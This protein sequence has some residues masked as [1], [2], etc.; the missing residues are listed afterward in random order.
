[1]CVCG[2]GGG[3]EGA[4]F[5]A[6]LVSKNSEDKGYSVVSLIGYAVTVGHC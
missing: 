3:G 6:E 2:G 1:M 4:N 5:P